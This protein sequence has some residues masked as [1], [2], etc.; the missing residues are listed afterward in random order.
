MASN[1]ARGRH[2]ACLRH[3][4][5]PIKTSGPLHYRKTHTLHTISAQGTPLRSVDL[6]S[7][8][9]A[10]LDSLRASPPSHSKLL[11]EARMEK[12]SGSE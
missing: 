4:E 8:S 5:L 9:S 1:D 7:A 12:N 11:E 6:S 2:I 3:L 10:P